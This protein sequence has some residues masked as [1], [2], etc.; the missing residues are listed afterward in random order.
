MSLAD[1]RRVSRYPCFLS[2]RRHVRSFLVRRRATMNACHRRDSR[3]QG[4]ELWTTP[5]LGDSC[6][7]WSAYRRASVIV[8]PETGR[9]GCRPSYARPIENELLVDG[10]VDRRSHVHWSECGKAPQSQS[11]FLPTTFNSN[12]LPHGILPDVCKP[13]LPGWVGKD[14]RSVAVLAW[15]LCSGRA[16]FA[17]TGPEKRK[18]KRC[19]LNPLEP[20]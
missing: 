9:G 16:F 7:Y 5:P 15:N 12:R 19:R 17:Q 11:S 13:R 6:G 8:T 1:L 10:V 18:W 4:D 14:G 20:R 3:E 2:T